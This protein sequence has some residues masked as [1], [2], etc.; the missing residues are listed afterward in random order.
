MPFGLKKS[1]EEMPYCV[2]CFG[3][4]IVISND[5]KTYQFWLLPILVEKFY[6]T[7]VT[8]NETERVRA[9]IYTRLTHTKRIDSVLLPPSLV[10]LGLPLLRRCCLYRSSL[11]DV[12]ITKISRLNGFYTKY[13]RFRTL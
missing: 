11:A 1:L 10:A 7:Q 12:I 8:R 6:Q 9:Y 5:V 2:S 4:H 13:L 3:G